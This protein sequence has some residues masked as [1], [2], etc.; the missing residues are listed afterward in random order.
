[1]SVLY[2]VVLQYLKHKMIPLNKILIQ[3][4]IFILNSVIFNVKEIHNVHLTVLRR[5]VVL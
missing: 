3:L 5:F 4:N 1:M 2:S